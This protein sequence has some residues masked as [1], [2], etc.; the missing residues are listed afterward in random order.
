MG[1]YGKS[2]KFSQELNIVMN[3]SADSMDIVVNQCSPGHVMDSGYTRTTL[4]HTWANKEY[5]LA[6]VSPLAS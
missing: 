2:T 6:S 1:K 4:D 5:I 3:Y